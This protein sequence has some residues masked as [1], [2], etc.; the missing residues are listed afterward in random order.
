MHLL[1]LS[2][3]HNGLVWTLSPSH[4]SSCCNIISHHF[5]YLNQ[6]AIPQTCQCFLDADLAHSFKVH[7]KCTFLLGMIS[8]LPDQMCHIL[9]LNSQSPWLAFSYALTL[10]LACQSYLPLLI[11]KLL[12]VPGQT[13]FLLDP[14]HNKAQCLMHGDPST[15]IQKMEYLLSA[16]TRNRTSQDLLRGTQSD[17]RRS[18]I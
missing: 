15:N 18:L 5:L 4:G 10:C 11:C 16:S 7:C 12:E 13:F 6:T 2:Q 1:H 8:D 3:R 14:S 9:P 17:L